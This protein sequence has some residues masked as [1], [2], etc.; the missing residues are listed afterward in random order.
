MK[1]NTLTRRLLAA[2]GT[3]L[4]LAAPAAHAQAFPERDLIRPLVADPI[5]PRNFVSVLGVD[6]NQSQSTFGSVGLGFNYG[7][8]RWSGKKPGDGWQ[9]GMFAGFNSQFDLEESS[10]PLINTDYR[11]G[12]PLSFRYGDLSGRVRI[13]H[14]SSHLG[15][16]FILY[17]HPPERIDLSLEAVDF[18]VAWERAGWR[19][20]VGALYT[21][22]S[23]PSDLKKTAIHAGVDYAGTQPVLWGGRLVG[24]LDIRA[25]EESDWRAG[26]SAKVGLEFG[27]RA[28]DRRGITVLLEYF[29]GPAP[30]GQFYRDVITYYGMGVQFDF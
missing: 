26:V 16:E 8:Y 27:R 10:Y 21:F 11:V 3:L 25:L 4:A 13:F 30:F 15:D 18:L 24:G 1:S 17:G 2:C 6:T 14:Q 23:T 29:D 12:F 19:P 20:Y 5:E 9:L 7:L 22:H 28:P